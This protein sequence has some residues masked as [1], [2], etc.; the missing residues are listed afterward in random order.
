[1]QSVNLAG[2]KGVQVG[3]SASEVWGVPYLPEL[4]ASC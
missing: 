3:M 2:F 4:Q 1:M